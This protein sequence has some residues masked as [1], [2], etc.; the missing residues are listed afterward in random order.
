MAKNFTQGVISVEKL[1]ILCASEKVNEWQ[2]RE[3]FIEKWKLLSSHLDHGTILF[4][5]GMHGKADG[6]LD[7]DVD[8]L[9]TMVRQFNVEAMK[10]VRDEMEERIINAEFLQ[11]LNFLK[12]PISKNIDIDSLKE[13][14]QTI[15][16]DMVVMVCL[17]VILVQA[18]L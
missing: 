8:S 4:I 15:S 10:P 17:T 14:I 13:V 9:E 1:A 3:F 12:D 11:I 6:Q 7:E 16:P 2:I 18:S 5:A